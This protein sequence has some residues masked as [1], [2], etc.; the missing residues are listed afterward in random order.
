MMM[1]FALCLGAIVVICLVFLHRVSVVVLTG[2]LIAM[3]DIDLVGAIQCVFRA[4][5]Q[6]VRLNGHG[7]YT[8]IPSYA[9]K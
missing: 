3:I 9:C 8:L 2:M 6:A 1:N 4:G 5:A 7:A